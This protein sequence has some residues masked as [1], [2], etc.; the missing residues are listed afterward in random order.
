MLSKVRDALLRPGWWLGPVV[1]GALLLTL[2]IPVVMYAGMDQ[3][4]RMLE[5]GADGCLLLPWARED[6]LHALEGVGVW[7]RPADLPATKP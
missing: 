4:A 5:E 3:R 2:C 6:L 7:H 1:S